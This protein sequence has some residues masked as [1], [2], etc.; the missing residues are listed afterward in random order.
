VTF[1]QPTGRMHT[2]MDANLS[3]EIF[4]EKLSGRL[5]ISGKLR[6]DVLTSSIVLDTPKVE[7]INL[8][9]ASEKDN[10]LL[11]VLAKKTVAIC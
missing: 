2:A 9:A 7:S 11:S 10:D 6:F 4:N 8:D 1:D 3:S 5:G